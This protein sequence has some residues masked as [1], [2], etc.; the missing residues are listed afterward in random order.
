MRGP[1]GHMHRDGS[2]DNGH[3]RYADSTGTGYGAIH[4]DTCASTVEHEQTM[5]P[6]LETAAN[7]TDIFM[8]EAPYLQ[9]Q[10]SCCWMIEATQAHSSPEEGGAPTLL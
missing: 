7:E 3:G 8:H 4:I 10:R 6:A 2:L 5:R 1:E 9:T